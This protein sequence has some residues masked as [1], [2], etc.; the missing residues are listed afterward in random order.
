MTCIVNSQFN[1]PHDTLFFVFDIEAI[2]AVQSPKD[3]KI[4]N[5]AIMHLVS[6]NHFNLWVDPQLSEYS[7]P[8]HPDLYPVTKEFLESKNAKPFSICGPLFIQWI[9][10]FIKSPTQSVVLIS[11]GNHVLDKPI[12]EAEFGKLKMVLPNNWFFFDTL[13]YCRQKIKK[14]ESYSLKNLYSKIFKKKIPNQHF[15]LADTLALTQILKWCLCQEYLTDD[16]L[17]QN[18]H[19]IYYPPYYTPL[20]TIKFCG[21]Y[22][23]R[24]LVT[25][26]VQCV[27][28]LSLM[29]LQQHR[30]N[31]GSMQSFLMSQYF[32]KMESALRISNSVLEMILLS[33]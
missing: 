10:Q 15:A 30:L 26:G 25:N 29:L 19:G 8:P 2:G 20:Q 12:L 23:E 13:A 17:S 4:W 24:L 9:Q 22:N 6:Q 31:I 14:T 27:E 1:L 28:D 33:K 11:H 32:I 5:L 3:C 18:L 16:F 21:N 7:K